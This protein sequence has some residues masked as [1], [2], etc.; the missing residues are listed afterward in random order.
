MARSGGE[1]LDA[2]QQRAVEV[3]HNVVV[4]AGAGSGKTRVLTERYMALLRE[5]SAG[6]SEILAL[7][8]TRKAAAEMFSRI[9]RM[10]RDEAAD[11]P[12]LQRALHRFDEARIS[13]IDSFCAGILRDGAA[14][15]GLPARVET[16]DRRFVRVARRHAMSFLMDY[17]DEPGVAGFLRQYGIDGTTERLLIPLITRYIRIADDRRFIDH[18]AAQQRWLEEQK[19][20]VEA[21]IDAVIGRVRQ[22]TP[23]SPSAVSA[24]EGCLARD[25]DYAELHTFLQGVK[26]TFGSK[27]D[28]QALKEE[29]NRLLEKKNGTQRGLLPDW[30][31]MTRTQ[32]RAEELQNLYER[33]DDL[34]ER[35][36]AERRAT[37][38][39]SHQDVMELAVQILRDD[40][41]IR[42]VYRNQFRFIMIDEF[43]DNNAGQRDLLFLL[44][45]SGDSP[46]IP[47]VD[48]LEPSKLFFVG[49]Q[50]Q[51]IYRFRGADVSVFRRLSDDVAASLPTDHRAESELEL[52]TNY[53]SE[54][55]LISFFNALFPGYLELLRR[56]TRRSSP[57]F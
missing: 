45:D 33:F 15:F 5:E 42:R 24:H 28:A 53:R 16:D 9:Y 7:T 41:E 55:A 32:A 46:G 18:Y 36:L 19:Q 23:G 27:G 2:Q 39:L 14:R 43:Q 34:R 6:V 10:L 30:Y 38:L 26:K 22:L 25:G 29:L 44:A 1:T 17:G 47:S 49:D 20:T 3:R 54:P 8:F 48:R 56:S 11:S 51:S 35:V 4:S 52:A 31:A 21:E 13:T 40:P 37:G 57:R 12:V 50:K